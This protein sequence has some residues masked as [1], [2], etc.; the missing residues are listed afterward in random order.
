MFDR[1][2]AG[3]DD[4]MLNVRNSGLEFMIV[5]GFNYGLKKLAGL[6]LIFF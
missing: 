3:F 1:F 5:G 6:N 4:L 2:K